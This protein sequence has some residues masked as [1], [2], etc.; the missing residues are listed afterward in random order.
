MLIRHEI[1]TVFFSICS[2]LEFK[3]AFP[4]MMMP[5]GG[6]GGM[7]T[8]QVRISLP[9]LHQPITKQGFGSG[10]FGPDSD[11]FPLVRIKIK[12]GSKKFIKSKTK[13]N[14]IT[15]SVLHWPISFKFLIK[16]HN[17]DL[18]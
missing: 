6:Q 12:S 17:L 16:E 4:N 7:N 2:L 10:S 3:K 14:Y 15:H 1:L 11:F 13:Q 9:T 18:K 8:E 5:S